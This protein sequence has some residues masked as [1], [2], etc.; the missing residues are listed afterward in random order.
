ML[1]RSA[2]ACRP[3]AKFARLFWL[4]AA[5]QLHDHAIDIGLRELALLLRALRA[6]RCPSRLSL[7]R[8]RRR[9]GDAPVVALRLDRLRDL[10]RVPQSLVLDHCT[11]IDLGQPV[12]F[13]CK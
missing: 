4:I 2:R 11:L 6:F 12:R 5:R 1:V 7:I 9:A 13:W 8:A 3:T 10:Q